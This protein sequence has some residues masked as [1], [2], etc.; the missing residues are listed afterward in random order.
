MTFVH[1]ALRRLFA[2]LLDPLAPLGPA[3][4]LIIVSA[5]SGVALLYAF[6]WTSNPA[7]IAAARKRTQA[8]LLAV[9]LY[10]H[11]L[12]VVF[13]SQAQ[14]LSALGAYLAGMMVPFLAVALPFGLLFA[15]LDA[16]YA[17]RAVHPGEATVVTATAVDVD[18]WRLEAPE[19][20]R[21]EAGPVRMRQRRQISWRVRPLRE[22]RFD[23]TVA[24]G[25]RRIGKQ[26]AVSIA[27]VGAAPRRMSA[28]IEA[29]FAA[30]SEA[31]I[32]TAAGATEVE[33]EYPPL[34]VTA[35]GLHWL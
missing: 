19:G 12:A 28:G 10:R 13:R 18:G 3:W 8:H 33:V 21:V 5:V 6:R 4:S 24:R 29:L 11:D 35:L 25:G 1:S 22:G 14:F 2:L 16:R 34:G 31:A 9:R 27:D 7:A 30:P 32:Q 26:L 17:C 23:V 15:H 20:V